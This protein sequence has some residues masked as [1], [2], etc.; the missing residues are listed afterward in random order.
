[1]L[2]ANKSEVLCSVLYWHYL[3]ENRYWSGCTE[4]DQNSWNPYKETP[5]LCVR[6]TRNFLVFTILFFPF[7]FVKCCDW[8]LGHWS[9]VGDVVW[10]TMTLRR[11]VL[12][13]M[14]PLPGECWWSLPRRSRIFSPAMNFSNT[15][16]FF[17]RWPCSWVFG[18]FFFTLADFFNSLDVTYFFFVS[19]AR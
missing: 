1:M 16:S 14:L 15:G 4:R 12:P 13:G 5:G 6:L 19:S 8:R 2:L 3:L 18:W 17:H 9:F 10:A 7:S 11:Y